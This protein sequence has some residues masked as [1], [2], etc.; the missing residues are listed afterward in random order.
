MTA[1]RMTALAACVAVLSWN[2]ACADAPDTTARRS[3]VTATQAPPAPTGEDARA[4]PLTPPT[5]AD[6]T[7]A[8]TP[9]T[10]A[11]L[12]DMKVFPSF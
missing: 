1:G 2:T 8:Q 9:A 10:G 4:K 6:V 5:P 12:T 7:M 11:A 3:D